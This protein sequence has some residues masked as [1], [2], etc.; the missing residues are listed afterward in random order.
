MHLDVF[1]Y[2]KVLFRCLKCSLSCLVYKF[3]T[4]HS[5]QQAVLHHQAFAAVLLYMINLGNFHRFYLKF[6]EMDMF[7]EELESS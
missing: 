4:K 1:G 2:L 5:I 3:H 7:S 6:S